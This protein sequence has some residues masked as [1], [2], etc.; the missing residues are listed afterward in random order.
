MMVHT[1]CNNV[2]QRATHG[3]HDVRQVNWRNHS[4]CP[5]D[6]L[7]LFRGRGQRGMG[8]EAYPVVVPVVGIVPVNST[9]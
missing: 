9:G 7:R 8:R 4:Q 2:Q 5:P 3:G 6:P 1:W